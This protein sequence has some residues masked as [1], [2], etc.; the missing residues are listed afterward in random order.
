V[1]IRFVVYLLLDLSRVFARETYKVTTD[2][3][4]RAVAKI[5]DTDPACL[6]CRAGLAVP[7]LVAFVE[8]VRKQQNGDHTFAADEDVRITLNNFAASV[9]GESEQ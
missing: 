1:G 7:Q 8:A 4:S 5:L 2:I 9:L 3:V 6:G